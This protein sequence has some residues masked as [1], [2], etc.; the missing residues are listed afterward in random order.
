MNATQTAMMEAQKHHQLAAT[1]DRLLRRLKRFVRAYPM[2]DE[3]MPE[4]DIV[5]VSGVDVGGPITEIIDAVQRD[6][7]LWRDAIP[8]GFCIVPKIALEKA[9]LSSDV[10]RYFSEMGE[11]AVAT[12][13]ARRRYD[14]EQRRSPPKD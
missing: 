9:G 13:A 12:H 1:M 2:I 6:P 14:A 7:A 5:W 10:I 4:H 3:P 8:E 11:A